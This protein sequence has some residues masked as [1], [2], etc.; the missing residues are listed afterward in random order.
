MTASVPWVCLNM[1]VLLGCQARVYMS[2]YLFFFSCMFGKFVFLLI[3]ENLLQLHLRILTEVITRI[4]LSFIWDK[5]E[6]TM[7]NIVDKISL[8]DVPLVTLICGGNSK[9]MN[10]SADFH[11]NRISTHESKSHEGQKC[12]AQ[13]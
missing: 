5:R 3:Q 2:R 10:N 9:L 6:N 8:D 13:I 7:A 1:R 11:G 12:Q 4:Q